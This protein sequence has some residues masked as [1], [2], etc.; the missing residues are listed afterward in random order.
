MSSGDGGIIW[1]LRA[2]VNGRPLE[3]HVDG[4]LHAAFIVLVIETSPIMM[5]ASDGA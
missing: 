1:G 3:R 4:S 5:L 2:R